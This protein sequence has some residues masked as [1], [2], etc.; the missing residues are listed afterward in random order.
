MPILEYPMVLCIPM[1]AA[2]AS[3]AEIVLPAGMPTFQEMHARHAALMCK[4]CATSKTALFWI[5]GKQ[6]RVK[7]M[8]DMSFDGCWSFPRTELFYL[9]V[10]CDSKS[11]ASQVHF[12]KRFPAIDRC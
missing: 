8:K 1:S 9:F 6:Y 5:Q 4:S 2:K 12:I 10:F 11:C 7:P 3:A